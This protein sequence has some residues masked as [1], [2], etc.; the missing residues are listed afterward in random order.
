MTDRGDGEDRHHPALHVAEATPCDPCERGG[1]AAGPPGRAGGA[2]GVRVRVLGRGVSPPRVG[3]TTLSRPRVVRGAAGLTR[4]YGRAVRREIQGLRAVAVLLVVLFHLWPAVPGGYVGVDVFF[5]ISGFLITSLLLREVDRTGSVEP[6]AFWA[7]RMRR[8][9]PASYLVLVVSAVG[10]LAAEP[11]LVWQQFF[12]EILA[13]ALYVE[14]WALAL[15]SVDYLAAREHAL[16]GPALL[17]ALGRGAV[18]PGLAAARAR[19]ASGS[20]GAVVARARLDERVFAVLAVGTVALARLLALDHRRPT[21]PGPTS[22]P[23]PGPGSSAPGALLAFAPRVRPAPAPGA[24]AL[25]GWAAP[26][27]AARL[28]ARARRE[29]TPMPGTAAIWV[30]VASA[31]LIWVEDPAVPGRSS[32]LLGAASGAVARRHLLLDLPVALAADHPAALRHRPP[33]DQAR[34]GLDPDGDDRPR[35]R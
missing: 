27:R 34:P 24:A 28:R 6:G 11:R 5:V 3:Q 35:P 17:D 31:A 4:L 30:V 33:A 10:V 21:P 22:S 25:L 29:D 32:R 12:G 23:R 19:S 20:R 1:S 15:G 18:L 8:L 13:A 16:A 9:L 7:R 2:G 26:G 14:N